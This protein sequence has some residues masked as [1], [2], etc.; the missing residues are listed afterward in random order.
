[1]RQVG[2]VR[3]RRRSQQGGE[4]VGLNLAVAV[5]V[6]LA[7][8]RV[9][10]VRVEP[11]VAET[12]ER[13]EQL[14][15]VEGAGLVEVEAPE[16]PPELRRRVGAAEQGPRRREG[17]PLHQAPRLAARHAVPAREGRVEARDQLRRALLAEARHR[18]RR[19]IVREAPIQG[20]RPGAH[21]DLLRAR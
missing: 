13:P 12:N 18:H 16:D 3:R 5:G 8:E 14:R 19:R 17:R 10:R 1:M 20:A 9:D 4:L 15:R 7:D 21:H 11:L 6:A 2:R